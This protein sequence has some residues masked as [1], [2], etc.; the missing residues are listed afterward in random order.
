M[1]FGSWHL[2]QMSCDGW[3]HQATPPHHLRNSGIRSIFIAIHN[4]GVIGKSTGTKHAALSLARWL[5][6][7]EESAHQASQFCD[8]T[9]ALFCGVNILAG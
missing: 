7:T 5:N 2:A 8:L 6:F 1:S 4:G 9:I 3:H